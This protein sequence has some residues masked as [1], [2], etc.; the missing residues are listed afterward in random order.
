VNPAT[1]QNH[2]YNGWT[3]DH[4][5]SNVIAFCPDG[6]I[7]LCCLN[8]PGSVHDSM[9]TE[10]GNIYEKLSNVY[11]SNGGKCAVDSAFSM[12]RYP[13]LVKSSQSDPPANNPA[14]F[15]EGVRLNAEATAMRQS[16]E[17]GMR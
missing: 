13:F 10:W 5:V 14:E 12:K 11:E 2:F 3:H 17:W 1:V 8:V 4:Y 7:P 6:T 9:V 16:A 15:V